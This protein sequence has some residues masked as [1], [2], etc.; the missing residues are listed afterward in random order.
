MAAA[1]LKLKSDDTQ[2][3]TPMVSAS[4]ERNTPMHQ[5][6]NHPR[7]H[8]VKLSIPSKNKLTDKE[9]QTKPECGSPVNSTRTNELAKIP[10]IKLN[11]EQC[12]MQLPLTQLV[13]SRKKGT[14]KPHHRRS[15]HLIRAHNQS[16]HKTTT[17]TTTTNTPNQPNAVRPTMTKRTS[18]YSA[19]FQ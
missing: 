1:V 15:K 2:E 14:A 5:R 16:P 3:T 9:Q 6:N 19:H 18:H 13:V 7:D 4:T 11:H 10:T 8:Q 17:L 12:Q